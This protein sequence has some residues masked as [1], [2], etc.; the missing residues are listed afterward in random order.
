VCGGGV[1]V[2]VGGGG[3]EGGAV[4]VCEGAVRVLVGGCA[5]ES[6]TGVLVVGRGYLWNLHCTGGTSGS[7]QT[8]RSSG[9]EVG[10]RCQGG[11]VLFG[12]AVLDQPGWRCPFVVVLHA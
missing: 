7:S 9:R 4:C 2:C 3:E 6:P 11:G 5:S 10:H 12:C 8:G 1:C